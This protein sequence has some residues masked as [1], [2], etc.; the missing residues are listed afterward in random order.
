MDR[1]ERDDSHSRAIFHAI[2]IE[3]TDLLLSQVIQFNLHRIDSLINHIF[4]LFINVM[5]NIHISEFFRVI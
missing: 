4:F 2:V 3:L 1:A 5:L